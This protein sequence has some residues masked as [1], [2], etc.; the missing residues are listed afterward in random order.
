MILKVG[1]KRVEFEKGKA[2]ITVGTL[3]KLPGVI[4]SLIKAVR[5]ALTSN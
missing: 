1:S 3:D 4:D 5:R 2:A